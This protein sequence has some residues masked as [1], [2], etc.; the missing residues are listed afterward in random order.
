M[1]NAKVTGVAT[2]ILE[3]NIGDIV[4]VCTLDGLT[5]TFLWIDE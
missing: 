4:K 3:E 5:D 2:Q 1:E